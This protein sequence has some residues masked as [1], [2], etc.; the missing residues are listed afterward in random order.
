MI[1]EDAIIFDLGG[2][3]IRLDY[4]LTIRAFEQL[5]IT[6]FDV[7]YNQAAQTDLFDRYETGK[8]SSMQFINALLAYLPEGTSANQAVHAW[9]AMILDV[10]KERIRWLERLR[11]SHRLFLLS[12]TNDL[13]MPIV[14]RAWSKVSPKPLE[15]F[16]DTVY[17]SYTLG[18]RKPD[19]ATFQV[20]CEQNKL[21]PDKAIF[22]DD[23]IQHVEG[24]RKAGLR[25][26]HLTEF[27]QFDT[28]FS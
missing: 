27:D 3:L 24:A 21:K 25:V 14:R 16:F 6:D 13:H 19:V 15:T 5:G 2:V 26:H 18:M 7:L 12:N 11:Q 10:P 4:A 28:L 8:I 22:I 1:K 20:V 17:L 23:S 9:N